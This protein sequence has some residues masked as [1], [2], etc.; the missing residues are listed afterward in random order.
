MCIALVLMMVFQGLVPMA[1]VGDEQE[2]SRDPIDD[3]DVLRVAMQ[4]DIPN[5][6]I[7]DLYSNSYWKDVIL[8]RWC[9]EGLMGLDPEGN[10]FPRLAKE[11]SLDE[12]NLTVSITLREDVRF[13]DGEIMD[14]D[15][16]IFTYTA[17]RELTTYSDPIIQAFDSPSQ[18]S[19]GVLDLDE[20][21]GSVDSDGDGVFEG[22]SKVGRFQVRMVMGRPYSG[23]FLETL[24]VPI[25]PEHV[26]RDH[27]D[28]NT[29]LD[30]FWGEDP[31]ATIGTGP[32]FYHSGV[33]DES[34][35]IVK[36]EEYWGKEWMTP[37]GHR[38]YP[39]QV[40][41]IDF[42][43][44]HYNYRDEAIRDLGT[45]HLDVIPTSVQRGYVYDLVNNP[46]TDV[47]N[48][49]QPT[50]TF[51]TFN[52]KREPMNM[53]PFRKAVSHM[54][55]K[56]TIVQEYLDGFGTP[57]DSILAPAW[58]VGY[59]NGSVERYDYDLGMARQAL[60][61]G[62]FTGVGTD[63]RMPD[64]RKVPPLR[65]TTNLNQYDYAMDWGHSI[66]ESLKRL[67]IHVEFEVVDYGVFSAKTFGFD[68]D[69]SF[70]YSWY[71]RWWT[72]TD[73]LSMVFDQVGPLSSKNVFGFWSE[74]NENPYHNEMGGVSTLADD[75]TQALADELVELGTRIESAVDPSERFMIVKEAQGVISKAIPLNVIY[76]P[77]ISIPIGTEW[78]GWVALNESYVWILNVYSLGEL[79]RDETPP[80]QEGM[81]I[82]L[83]LPDKI[84]QG[85]T[86]AGNVLV[87]GEEGLPV[88]K[89][90]VILSGKGGTF[91]PQAG[92]TGP[93]GTF[94]FDLV[95]LT[96]GY[97]LLEAVATKGTS[98]ATVTS[99]VQVATGMP[100]LVFLQAS[101][102]KLFL[103]PGEST[104][105]DLRVTD[106]DAR[107]V[108]GTVVMLDEQMMGVG[109]IE[110]KGPAEVTTDTN[111]MATMTYTA[112]ASVP[113]N[114]H[115][116][117]HLAFSPLLGGPFA[118][119]RGNTVTQILT[120]M[121]PSESQWHFVKVLGA[122]EFAM[123]AM[124]TFTRV[125]IQTMDANG[126]PLS[127]EVSISYS[128]PD[129][130]VEPP[131]TV[132]TDGSG[133]AVLTLEFD[134]D[135]DTSATQVSFKNGNVTNA[136]GSVMTLLFR[137][138]EIPSEPLYGGYLTLD[139]TPML[140]PDTLDGLTFDI[141]LYD[142]EGNPTEGDVPVSLI[143]GHPGS[144]NTIQMI[145]EPDCIWNPLW[146][147][148][149][150]LIATET[151]RGTFSSTGYFLS[152]KMSDSELAE[153][154]GEYNTWDE[155]IEWWW[156]ELPEELENMTSLIVTDGHTQVAIEGD[157]VLLSDAVGT[158]TIV[159][160]GRCGAAD[161]QYL[162]C[163]L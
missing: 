149:S 157:R 131:S 20:I 106:K 26:W 160:G 9:F 147:D 82:L 1:T 65:I 104:V 42:R 158:I 146:D 155:Y 48:F 15:D 88:S 148:T 162:L 93:D 90:T 101:P 94:T 154:E 113:H 102:E 99:R 55:D 91:E 17:L 60:V 152:D 69:M 70:T 127:E 71:P 67:G 46:W 32:F 23:F 37:S 100:P 84:P 34:R 138:D 18:G 21:N 123:D 116:Q 14:A 25:I 109:D 110:P 8:G 54:I 19:D 118:E 81:T 95:G 50:P 133:Q 111:G 31:N 119:V 59:Y 139:E 57:G 28:D 108:E 92:T 128:N 156:W 163:G 122:T 112:P 58:D 126:D 41:I 86:T 36:F 10:I 132:M 136:I 124:N 121:N 85:R 125:T 129:I 141:F 97:S 75:Q 3:G 68:Y 44:Y 43:L 89:A 40:D 98:S 73:P 137:G 38:I 64:G 117:V 74:R 142:I 12:E 2:E 103:E 107:G 151:D 105:I 61:D 4:E 5:F 130:L 24:M 115:L 56:E 140:N 35:R 29:W 33:I 13:H 30:I 78:E 62:G 145:D 47:V 52:M 27:V 7:F 16:V 77:V 87:I 159:P 6:N 51:L 45:G 22:I 134:G 72:I 96:D 150:T 49:T 39:Q 11:W 143:L 83:N 135:G 63:L 144:D 120:I 79:S 80:H 161:G 66:S 76:Y 153:M 53:L 114:H